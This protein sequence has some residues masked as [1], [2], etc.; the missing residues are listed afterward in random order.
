M[1]PKTLKNIFSVIKK[2]FADFGEYKIM[3]LSASLAYTTIF[4]M[5]PLIV[6]ILF[7]CAIFFQKEAIEGTLY[8]QIKDFVGAEGAA[9]IQ[10]MIKNSS[11]TTSSI[12]ARIASVVALLIAA[13]SLFADIQDSLNTI[14]GVRPKQGSGIKNFIKSRILS[15]GIIGG[16]GFLLLVT[17]G[18]S[19]VMDGISDR[20]IAHFSNIAVVVIYIVNALFTLIVVS[21]LFAVIFKVLPDAEIRWRQIS[22]SAIVTAIL[23]II[24]K[25]LISLYISKTNVGSTF[26]A[27]GSLVVLLVWVY[28]SSLIL[29]LGAAFAK[30]WALAFG[31]PILPSKHAETIQRVEVAAKG[32]SLQQAE[33]QKEKV[34][35][36]KTL[37]GEVVANANVEKEKIINNASDKSIK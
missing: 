33:T 13:T 22:T 26:G 32:N 16:L 4:S 37:A 21:T 7:L 10:S 19:S 30:Q 29:Y 9:Q 3:K 18:I 6:M 35:D 5:A 20:L 34:L 27:A 36:A 25:F 23:F 12:F 15:F 31:T 24:G 8:A 28:Y 17:L 1:K 14:W 11:K 2:T